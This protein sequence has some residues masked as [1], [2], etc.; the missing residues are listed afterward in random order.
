M[1]MERIKILVTLFMMKVMIV[2][3]VMRIRIR[4]EAAVLQQ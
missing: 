2:M 4:R 3:I 1:T